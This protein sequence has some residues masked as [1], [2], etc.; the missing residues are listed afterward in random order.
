MNDCIF[1]QIVSGN[2]PAERVSEDADT[3]A[4][5]DIN[6]VRPGHLLLIPRA[7][8]ETLADLPSNLLEALSKKAQKL[9][10]ALLKAGETEGYNLFSN[11]HPC[12]GQ[13]IPHFHYHLVPRRTGDGIKF[14]WETGVYDADGMESWGKRIRE[15]LEE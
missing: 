1:C 3:L 4:F 7:H 6:P 10:R 9:A 13:A 11:N 12:S 15:A 2:L 8:H 5:L 14:G